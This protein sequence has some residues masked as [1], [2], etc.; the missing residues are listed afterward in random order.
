MTVR[1]FWSVLL[2][3]AFRPLSGLPAKLPCVTC[4]PTVQGPDELTREEDFTVRLRVLELCFRQSPHED[5]CSA[6]PG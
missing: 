4:K 5:C 3:D 2:A 1:C 6:H